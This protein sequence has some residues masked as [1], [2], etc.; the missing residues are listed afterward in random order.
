M[1]IKEIRKKT[2]KEVTKLL[3]EQR[4]RLRDLRFKISSRQYK[5]YKEVGMVK[6]EIAKILTVMNERRH[7]KGS[8]E[9]KTKK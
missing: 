8:L 7:Y 4:E 3:A 5:N 6:K 9:L 2:D 1:E